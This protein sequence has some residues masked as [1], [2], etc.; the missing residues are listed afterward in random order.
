MRRKIKQP[1]R[2]TRA[3]REGKMTAFPVASG[4]REAREGEDLTGE[5]NTGGDAGKVSH[6]RTASSHPRGRG[7]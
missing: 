3:S 5:R 4:V 1:A 2:E 7:A 6:E